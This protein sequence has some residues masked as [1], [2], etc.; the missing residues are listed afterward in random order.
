[1]FS[2]SDLH[3]ESELEMHVNAQ[4]NVAS[5]QSFA[6]KL[7]THQRRKMFAKFQTET[8]ITSRDTILDVG[9][10]S[11]Q[12]YE[13]SNYF[14]AWYPFKEKI[15][16]VGLDDAR[17]LE[18]L[19]PGMKF[20]R[21]D[22]GCLPFGN[23]DFDF[24]HSSA[25]LEHVGG[26]DQQTQFLKEL[27]RVARKGIFVTTP[28]RWFP[29]EFHTVLPFIHWLPVSI[30]RRLLFALGHGF[31]ADERNLN[32]LSR[33]SLAN[34]ARQAGVSNFRVLSASLLGWPTNLLLIA[35]K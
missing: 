4:Y 12:G 30:Y 10:T 9:V 6:V 8:K 13:H 29:V 7:A 25:V 2:K 17:F 20:V 18:D 34:A 19:Y 16:A 1:M 21:A 35:E 28:N 32:L 22:G 24:V 33:R 23:G 27:W 26:E 11:D 5:P 31:F 3:D 15:T 14:E